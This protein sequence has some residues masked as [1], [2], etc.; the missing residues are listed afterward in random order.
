M[1]QMHTNTTDYTKIQNFYGLQVMFS[2]TYNVFSANVL[3]T[4]INNFL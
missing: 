1:E 2:V 4:D 3:Q